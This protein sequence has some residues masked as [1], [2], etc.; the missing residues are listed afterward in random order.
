M[1]LTL[2]LKRAS[3]KTP[4]QMS[5]QRLNKRLRTLWRCVALPATLGGSSFDT[6]LMAAQAQDQQGP[7]AG[8]DA[9]SVTDTNQAAAHRQS[10][11][12]V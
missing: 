3:R 8:K 11:P 6:L 1:T 12:R 2:R 5:T 4:F 7:D 10:H 9:T